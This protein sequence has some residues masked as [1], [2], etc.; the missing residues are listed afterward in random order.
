MATVKLTCGALEMEVQSGTVNKV[1]LP[2]ADL[3]KLTILGSD[4]S[5]TSFDLTISPKPEK[6]VYRS[7]CKDCEQFY[8]VCPY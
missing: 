1:N 8:C 4:G 6:V 3:L 7:P 5:V 2:A